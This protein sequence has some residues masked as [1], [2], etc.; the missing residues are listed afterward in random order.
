MK[1]GDLVEWSGPEYD[2]PDKGHGLIVH[3]LV[4]GLGRKRASAEVYWAGWTGP[5]MPEMQ[6]TTVGRLEVINESR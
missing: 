1:V 6:W 4:G 5:G 3:I 2:G